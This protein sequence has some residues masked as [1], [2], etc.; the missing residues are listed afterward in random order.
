MP[1]ITS[2]D[3]I[4][5]STVVAAEA[6]QGVAKTTHIPVAGVVCGLALEIVPMV[7]SSSFPSSLR[8]F[9]QR[10]LKEIAQFTL[11]LDK[12]HS[13]LRV[14]RE[15]GSIKRLFRQS[16]LVTQLNGCEAELK[17]ALYSFMM[18]HGREAASAVS[19]LNHDTQKLQSTKFV[20]FKVN[21]FRRNGTGFHVCCFGYN[22]W[23]YLLL[24]KSSMGEKPSWK[25]PE[26][27]WVIRVGCFSL[28][29]P[30][31][32]IRV[33]P[34][35]AQVLDRVGKNFSHGRGIISNLDF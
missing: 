16:Q 25:L 3:E 9:N 7:Q 15:L 30:M 1:L 8:T 4:V 31:M 28:S 5:E 22:S 33:K 24:Q 6:L 21:P 26:A 12:L 23:Y 2:M 19:Q 34:G 27:K 29:L 10:M 20:E 11:T 35:Y 18:E 17:S 32:I 14:Q 13:C